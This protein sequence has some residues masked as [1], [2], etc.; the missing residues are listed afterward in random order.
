V[1]VAQ[2]AQVC[3]AT[4]QDLP[5]ADE[6][7]GIMEEGMRPASHREPGI[8]TGSTLGGFPLL[9]LLA[10]G[11]MAE[12]YRSVDSQLRRDVAVK[13]LPIQLAQDAEY[14]A[15]FRLE[16]QRVAALSHPHVV[17][18]FR[19]GEEHGLLYLVM[20]L[21]S[22]SLSDRMRREGALEPTEAVRLVVQIAGALE[23]AHSH[24]LVHRDVKPENILLDNDG[25][26]LLTDFGIAR[27]VEVLR[28]GRA[29]PTLAATG[30]PIGTLE[31]MA[32]EQ[33]RGTVADQRADVYS[34][35]AVLFE[36]LTGHLPHGGTTHYEM[37]ASVL[38]EL[39]PSPSS[40]NPTIWPALAEAV[41]RA[42]AP[43]PTQRYS[44]MRSFVTALRRAIVDRGMSSVA[45]LPT[46]PTAAIPRP[47]AS[48]ASTTR[49]LAALVPVAP[50]GVPAE[51]RGVG[52]DAWAQRSLIATRWGD[53]L[54]P[55]LHRRARVVASVALLLVVALGA[56]TG[57]VLLSAY[58]R[59]PHDAAGK[60]I[61]LKSTTSAS[62]SESLD[63]PSGPLATATIGRA[64]SGQPTAGPATTATPVPTP[65][66]TPLLTPTITVSDSPLVFQPYPFGSQKPTNCV[67]TQKLTN[68]GAVNAT[69]SWT[70]A[71]AS[72]GWQYNFTG[73]SSTSWLGFKEPLTKT[74]AAHSSDYVYIKTSLT[75]L[76]CARYTTIATIT[77]TQG[78]GT[79][80][81]VKY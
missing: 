21:L 43:D 18:V 62:T 70:D 38:T 54:P 14:V 6:R 66:A 68:I 23:A 69:W 11:G 57:G 41:L 42:L 73:F 51:A 56:A 3:R 1:H 44:D 75:D 48:V 30:L 15:R 12:V 20:P 63:S 37:V 78:T 77:V 49:Q 71:P 60:D 5:K 22:E 27:E 26:A 31:Y 58:V 65:T 33:L 40:Y 79:Q 46:A 53:T 39:P 17:P 19:F 47:P 10:T 72:S 64:G 74:T 61:S 28:A 50:V 24:G 16:A 80:F 59:A 76:L 45:D 13:V 7:R 32:P 29:V 35:G 34:L 4:N 36:T 2:A 8:L 9:S 55:H 81:T 52:G 67:A 25:R